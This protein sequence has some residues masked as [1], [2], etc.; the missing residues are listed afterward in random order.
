MGAGGG[1]GGVGG[2]EPGCLL[3]VYKSA[4]LICI[5]EPSCAS[6]Q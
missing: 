5:D 4:I 2:W 3:L 1:V 6:V